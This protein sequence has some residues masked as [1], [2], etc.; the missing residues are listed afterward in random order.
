[1]AVALGWLHFR[2]APAGSFHPFCDGS[3]FALWLEHGLIM[4][5]MVTVQ[6]I[7]AESQVVGTPL[8]SR[9]VGEYELRISRR[10]S[11]LFER[12]LVRR[13][14]E[15]VVCLATMQ[16]EGCLSERQTLSVSVGAPLCSRYG[17]EDE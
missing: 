2:G 6:V 4:E 5:S 15:Q 7:V 3:G 12:E 17:G 13:G 10:Y 8:C 9:Y 1:M 16:A 14:R 11:G